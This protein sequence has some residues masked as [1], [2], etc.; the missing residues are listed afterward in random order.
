MK[1]LLIVIVSIAVLILVIFTIRRNNKELKI[2]EGELKNDS[3]SIK[4]DEANVEMDDKIK[5]SQ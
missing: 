3:P 5:G 4:H 1:I 2:F